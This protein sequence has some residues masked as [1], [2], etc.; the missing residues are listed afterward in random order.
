MRIAVLGTGMVGIALAGKLHALGHEVTMGAREAGNEKAREWAHAAGSGAREGSFADAASFGEIVVNCT[1]GTHSLDALDAAGAGNLAGKVLVDVANPLDFSRGM[2]P[3]LTV[4][5]TDSLGE[6]IQRRFPQA[7]V[8]KALNTVNCA[9]MVDPAAVPG[10]HHLFV[11]GDD[12]AAK[13]TVTDLLATFGW[14]ADRVIDLGGITA[15]RGTEMFLPLWV[16]L[17][18]VL[19][20]PMF[21]VAVMRAT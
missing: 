19:G 3:T 9:V 13:R 18:G 5:N 21:N 4:A 7:R 15:A 1:A 2:P 6:R 17:Y 12:A 11:C 20:T 8:V 10:P 16:R 14:P